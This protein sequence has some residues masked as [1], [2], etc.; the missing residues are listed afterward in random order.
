MEAK[1]KKAR[2]YV[3]AA[4][5][6]G[7]VA[8]AVIAGAACSEESTSTENQG[9]KPTIGPVANDPG[10]EMPVDATPSPDGKDIYFIA[11]S[12]VADEDNIGF[13]RQAAIYKVSAQGGPITKLHQGDPLVAPFGITISGD[14]QTLF[15]A[16]SG[17]TTSEDR[18]DGRVYTLGV[19]GGAPGPLSGT[20]GLAPGGVEVMGDFL[21]ITGRKDGKAGLFKTGLGGGQ[22]TTVAAN[23]SFV[24]PSGVAVSRN[25]E[26]YVVDSGSATHGQAM[27][28]VVKVMPDGRTEIVIDGLSVGHPAGIALSNDETTIFV[29]GFDSGKGT[30]VVF[31]V[32]A[33]SREIGQFTD[34][35]ADFS[36]SAG[37][38][39]ARNADVFAWADSHANGTGTVYVLRG[40]Q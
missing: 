4:A 8:T 26:A 23:E 37:L 39:R 12:K 14:G 22:L 40:Q 6:V 25:G 30:D 10:I 15:I 18:S 24:D 21:Y 33:A 28:S 20:E 11:N 7:A 36:E 1:V 29:S 13:L 9:P 38:H 31:T 3:R 16:D 34:S 35:I 27:A 17:A 32:N 2:R 19:G 5:I